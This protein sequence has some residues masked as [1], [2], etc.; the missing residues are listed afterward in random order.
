MDSLGSS[1][2]WKQDGLCRDSDP[3]AWF[4]KKGDS[5]VTAK[6]VCNGDRYH[7]PCPV[8]DQCLE[9]ALSNVEPFG[10]WGGMGERERRTLLAGRRTGTDGRAD[11]K[12]PGKVS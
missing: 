2:N 8:R 5:N 6:R 3:E 11:V 7:R 12:R 9:Y 4:P 10:V 1:Q